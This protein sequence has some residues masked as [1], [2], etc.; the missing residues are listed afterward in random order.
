MVCLV[1]II[2]MNKA[3]GSSP[4]V[5]ALIMKVKKEMGTFN[6]GLGMSS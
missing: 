6:N 2:H 4:F 1:Q 3:I 5:N